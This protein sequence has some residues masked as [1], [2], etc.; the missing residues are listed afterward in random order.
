MPTKTVI[1]KYDLKFRAPTSFIR[2]MIGATIKKAKINPPFRLKMGAKPEVPPAKTGKPIKPIK[3]Y[4]PTVV[5]TSFG[6]N[7]N[8]ITLIITVCA[9]TGVGV[10]GNGNA[11]YD[12]RQSNVMQIAIIVNF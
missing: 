3:R 7:N 2:L 5:M 1:N 9:V 10:N 4:R 6:F 12:E 8:A 11:I